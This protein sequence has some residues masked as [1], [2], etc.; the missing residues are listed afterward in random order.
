MRI[1]VEIP[2]E[3]SVTLD[4]VLA[5]TKTFSHCSK[6][7]VTRSFF[8]QSRIGYFLRYVKND[9]ERFEPT[10]TFP[11]DNTMLIEPQRFLWLRRGREHANN[12]G[13]DDSGQSGSEIKCPTKNLPALVTVPSARTHHFLIYN[14]PGYNRK[15][16]I[17]SGRFVK[18]SLSWAHDT[19][20]TW[21][22]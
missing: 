18:Y 9:Q 1:T 5:V 3:Q 21:T 16:G 14:R 12:S 7:W 20:Q 10:K 11:A 17:G 6:K 2:V 8:T 22:W 15:A 13:S 4:S 19:L